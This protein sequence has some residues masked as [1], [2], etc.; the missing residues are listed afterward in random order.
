MAVREV[1][2]GLLGVVYSK[3]RVGGLVVQGNTSTWTTGHY[4]FFSK[5]I[6][7]TSSI[8]YKSIW[9]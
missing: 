3:S 9:T 4:F 5:K 6:L 2:V 1:G 7:M 8:I